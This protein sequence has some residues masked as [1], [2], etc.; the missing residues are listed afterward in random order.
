[1]VT[2]DSSKFQVGGWGRGRGRGRGRGTTKENTARV[3]ASQV[4]TASESK[5]ESSSKSDVVGNTLKTKSPTPLEQF[6]DAPVDGTT[7]SG[8]DN[9]TSSTSSRG[10]VVEGANEASPP[11]GSSVPASKPKR[12]SSQRQQ[13]KTGIHV[14]E[15]LCTYMQSKAK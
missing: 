6:A 11:Q 9:S 7:T 2:S 8:A 1:M 10:A 3:G 12:Y 14:L 13:Q 4:A 15:Q 5:Q